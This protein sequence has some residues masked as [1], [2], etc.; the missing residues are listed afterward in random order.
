MSRMPVLVLLLA[1]AIPAVAVEEK[2]ALLTYR[3]DK[4]SLHADD[5]PLRTVLDELHKQSG[6]Q[7]RG[8]FPDS[9]KITARFD[10]VPMSAALERFLGKSNFT[11]GYTEAGRLVS[12]T[13]L[14]GPLP[15]PEKTATADAKESADVPTAARIAQYQ[16]YEASQRYHQAVWDFLLGDKQ[17]PVRGKLAEALGTNSITMKDLAVAAA[18]QPNPAVR[19]R[20][21]RASIELV[22][23]DSEVQQA[24]LESIGGLDDEALAHIARQF[25]Q[26]NAEEFITRL[27]RASG[28]RELR[29]RVPPILQHLSQ[30]GPEK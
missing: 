5:V 12:V 18:R 15:P 6:A 25:A 16:K 29:S 21:L 27:A 17:Y 9:A 23:S 20:A 28:S 30:I 3:D 4:L 24:F 2:P 14:G 10:D 1:L 11:L 8:E 13:L 19:G 7:V 22:R 26:N